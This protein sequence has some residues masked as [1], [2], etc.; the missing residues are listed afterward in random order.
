MTAEPRPGAEIQ[1]ERARSARILVLNHHGDSFREAIAEMR[2]AGLEVTESRSVGETQE[3]LAGEGLG[4]QRPDVVIL[5]PLVV[6]AGGVEIEMVGTLA[7]GEEP[8]PVILLVEDL[9]ALQEA[10]QWPV[11]FADFVVKPAS[12]PE[13]THR[14]ELALRKR[15]HLLHLH[16]RASDLAEQVTVD[17]KTGLLSERHFNNLLTVEFKRAQRHFLPLSLLLVDV[18]N[19]KGVN[20]TTEYGFGDE[21]LREVAKALKANVRETDFAARFGGDEFVVLLP[22]TTPAEAVHT[23]MRIRQRIAATIVESEAYTQQVTVSIGID[24]FDGRATTTPEELRRRANK[25]LHEAKRRGK[26]QVWLYSERAEGE[27]QDAV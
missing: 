3:L 25:A 18:D 22:H 17:F 1:G 21:V 9:P 4:A 7:N 19:F 14:V 2:Q 11:Q 27:P 24:T 10:A 12:G 20:D 16:Q 5:N 23:A 13:L 8:P 26:D 6:R 15:A